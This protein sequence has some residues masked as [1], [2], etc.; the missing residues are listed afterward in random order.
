V[1]NIIVNSSLREIYNFC[2]DNIDT[3]IKKAREDS[4]GKRNLLSENEAY[5]KIIYLIR[6]LAKEENQSIQYKRY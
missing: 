4:G 6:K 2:R 1:R 3:N 5:I